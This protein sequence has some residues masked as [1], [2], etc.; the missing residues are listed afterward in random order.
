[1]VGTNGIACGP[2][3][4]GLRKKGGYSPRTTFDASRKGFAKK[5]DR[6]LELQRTSSEITDPSPAPAV[7]APIIRVLASKRP[8]EK[9]AAVKKKCLKNIFA[10]KLPWV[11]CMHLLRE[12]PDRQV[13]VVEGRLH[14]REQPAPRP[15][16]KPPL[17]K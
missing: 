17:T 14:P 15:E 4:Q 9:H 3:S 12:R 6:L 5:R 2:S 16:R 8:D 7:C 13:C 10:R 11:R 1:M